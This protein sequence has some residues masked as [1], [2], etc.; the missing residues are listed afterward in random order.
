MNNNWLLWL[1]LGH[2]Y[3]HTHVQ[4]VT[5]FN[6]RQSTVNV[7]LILL[8]HA[9]RSSIPEIIRDIDLYDDILDTYTHNDDYT[10][11]VVAAVA[12]AARC[13]G[14]LALFSYIFFVSS[15]FGQLLCAPFHHKYGLWNGWFYQIHHCSLDPYAANRTYPKNIELLAHFHCP[16][17]IVR[18]DHKMF[19]HLRY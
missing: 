18:F 6:V 2:I 9:L 5:V 15:S 11:A 17:I 12:V 4:H 19:Y 8:Y 13:S 3:T 16:F 1:E 10:D 7:L 14:L